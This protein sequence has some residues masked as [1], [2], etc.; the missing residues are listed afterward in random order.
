MTNYRSVFRITDKSV[1]M[2]NKRKHELPCIDCL[3]RAT[4]FSEKQATK[5]AKY[6]RFTVKLGTPCDKALFEMKMLTLAED[7]LIP[8]DEI[9]AMNADTLLNKAMGYRSNDYRELFTG[10]FMFQTFINKFPNHRKC[11]FVYYH[12]GMTYSIH[13][14]KGGLDAA[15]EC[16]TK[17]INLNYNVNNAIHNRGMFL[18]EK[19]ELEKALAD[20]KRAQTIDRHYGP[21]VDIRNKV[22]K[23]IEDEIQRS[24]I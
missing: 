12:L 1:D 7:L 17:S 13:W 22:I 19:G 24:K 3:V 5:R 23:D 9:E 21:A 10:I 6:L 8:I 20:L 11:G 4:C 18:R 15:V 16:L 14:W 2:Y